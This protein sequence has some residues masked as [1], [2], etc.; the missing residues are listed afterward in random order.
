MKINE[1]GSAARTSGYFAPLQD[2]TAPE[3]GKKGRRQQ[4]RAAAFAWIT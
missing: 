3:T 2:N 1:A 4:V